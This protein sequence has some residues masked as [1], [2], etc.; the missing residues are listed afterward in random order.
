MN[1]NSKEIDEILDTMAKFD[2]G[3]TEAYNADAYDDCIEI[4]HKL[5]KVKKITQEQEQLIISYFAQ[6]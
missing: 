1:T 5:M 3:F 2:K 4:A 6:D